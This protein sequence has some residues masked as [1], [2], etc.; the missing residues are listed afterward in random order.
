MIKP[1]RILFTKTVNA[2][3]LLQILNWFLPQPGICT[4]VSL[5]QTVLPAYYSRSFLV[6][7]EAD[8]EQ[9]ELYK[10]VD[11]VTI[12][13]LHHENK[14]DTKLHVHLQGSFASWEFGQQYACIVCAFFVKAIGFTLLWARSHCS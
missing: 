5:L 7:S 4:H 10:K 9:L 2:H 3:V 12:K 13:L 14:G 11:W 1:G 8:L 6:W